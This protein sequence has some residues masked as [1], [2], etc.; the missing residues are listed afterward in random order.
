MSEMKVKPCV[1]CRS[2]RQC[3]KV[4][5]PDAE[6]WLCQYCWDKMRGETNIDEGNEQTRI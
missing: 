6:V 5:G 3:V 4:V 2:L 1:S